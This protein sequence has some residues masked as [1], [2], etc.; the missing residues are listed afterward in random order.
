VRG[1]T[2][3]IW[4]PTGKPPAADRRPVR[5][6]FFW[7]VFVVPAAVTGA[8]NPGAFRDLSYYCRPGPRRNGRCRGMFLPMLMSGTIA[9]L[10]ACWALD[11]APQPSI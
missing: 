7:P 9:A 3:A 2:P 10:C 1:G 11:N 6:R 5:K 8:S 4:G